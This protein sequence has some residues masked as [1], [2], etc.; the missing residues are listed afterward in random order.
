MLAHPSAWH[1]YRRRSWGYEMAYWQARANSYGLHAW[2]YTGLGVLSA[3]IA[4]VTLLCTAPPAWPLGGLLGT[5]IAAALALHTRRER[6][7]CL[8]FLYW[9]RYGEGVVEI[10][11]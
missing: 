1:V 10:R 3:T 2:G 8:T 11:G 4:M 5:T 6:S 9:T 7:A